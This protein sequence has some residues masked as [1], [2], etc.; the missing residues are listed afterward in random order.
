MSVFRVHCSFPLVA[1]A[2]FC[3][4]VANGCGSDNDST[5]PSA[6][7]PT[8]KGPETEN[9]GPISATEAEGEEEETGDPLDQI[10]QQLY[11]KVDFDGLSSLSDDEQVVYLTLRIRY[12]VLQGGL[13]YY[14]FN[15]A[16]KH[17]RETVTAL[18]NIDMKDASDLLEKACNLF[19]DETPAFEVNDRQIQL[20][21]FSDEQRAI[22]EELGETLSQSLETAGEKVEYYLKMHAAT[23]TTSN[24]DLFNESID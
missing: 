22:L 21:G 24:D 2:W 11:D 12:E 8:S 14:F 18:K 15:L 20:D 5:P 9:A 10:F 7:P 3:A 1:I 17:A 23:P 6:T 4:T 16:G 19:P 13:E